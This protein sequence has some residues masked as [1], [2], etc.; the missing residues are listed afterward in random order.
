V[1]FKVPPSDLGLLLHYSQGQQV[2]L[3]RILCSEVLISLYLPDLLAYQVHKKLDH[4][5]QL[6]F[7]GQNQKYPEVLRNL[8]VRIPLYFRIMK[9]QMPYHTHCFS[10]FRVT[11]LSGLLFVSR[12]LHPAHLR[13]FV[14]TKLARVSQLL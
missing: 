7:M 3:V 4:L 10:L 9:G 2:Y 13:N 1:S 11:P 12:C 5:V 6:T 8:K 14:F